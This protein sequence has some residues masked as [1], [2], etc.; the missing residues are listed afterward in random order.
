LQG[1]PGGKG[2]HG[3]HTN[4]IRLRYSSVLSLHPRLEEPVHTG[5]RCDCILLLASIALALSIVVPLGVALAQETGKSDATFNERFPNEQTFTQGPPEQTVS[6]PAP[7][8]SP[9][10]TVRKKEHEPA[11]ST[12][13][14]AKDAPTQ[15]VV[16]PRSFLD[17]GTELLP[18]ER[19]FL[20]YAFPPTRY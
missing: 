13:A 16:E 4:R 11:A 18:G 1:A 17:A 10:T 5:A 14:S 7:E 12:V 20:D 3:S 15:I 6:Q 9:R 19:K 8:I 2:A